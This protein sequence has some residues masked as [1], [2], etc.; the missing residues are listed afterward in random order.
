[1]HAHPLVA[2]VRS[3]GHRGWFSVFLRRVV[4]PIDVVVARATGGRLVAFGSRTF[5][6]LLLTTVGRRSGEP[7]TIPLLY[8]RDGDAYVVIGS[9]FGQAHQPAWSGNLLAHPEA[10]VTV[11]GRTL[12]VVARL[13]TGVERD[14]L[15]ALLLSMW[16]AYQTYQLRSGGRDMRIFRLAP[17]GDPT[18]P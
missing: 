17:A 9:N 3:L 7:R 14:R 15:F 11:A 16:P 6:S 8:A 12:P 2:G 10:T 18:A 4:V 13:A 1:M 5:P